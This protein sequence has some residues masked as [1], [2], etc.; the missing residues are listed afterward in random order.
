MSAKD[1]GIDEMADPPLDDRCA[2]CQ[3]MHVRGE[4]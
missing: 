1:R 2:A 3:G 4:A